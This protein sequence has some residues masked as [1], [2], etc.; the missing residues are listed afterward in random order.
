MYNVLGLRKSFSLSDFTPF[1]N[2]GSLEPLFAPTDANPGLGIPSYLDSWVNFF[3]PKNVILISQSVFVVSF[4][5]L[6]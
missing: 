1:K 5:K 4:L 6:F 2:W 3:F